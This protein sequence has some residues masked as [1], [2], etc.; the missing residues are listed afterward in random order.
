MS[1]S[2]R[3]TVRQFALIDAPAIPGLVFRGFRDASDSDLIAAIHAGRREHDQVDPLSPVE[4]VPAADEVARWLAGWDARDR[5]DNLLLVD[6]GTQGIGYASIVWW[7]E[8]D[9]TWLYLHE[10]LLRPEWR[11]RGIGTAMVHWAEARIRAIAATHPTGGKAM[12]G[13]NASSTEREASALLLHEGYR[14]VFTVLD[15]AFDA[16]DRLPAPELPARFELRPARPEHDRLIWEAINETYADLTNVPYGGAAPSEEDFQQFAANPAHDRSLWQVAW[17]GDQGAGVVL[18]ELARGRG[19]VTE[20]SVRMPWRRRG[21][22]RALL[23]R[24]LLALRDRGA[25][26]VRLHTTEEFETQAARLYEDV[27]FRVV[28]RHPRYRKPIE[29]S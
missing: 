20:C 18:C 4:R 26:V 15:M 8:P 17:D 19:V 9:G 28:K 16:F 23:V 3:R 11:G 6:V 14:P 1:Q 13:A 5:A 2:T 10:G 24:G 12:Y 21:V 29:A 22:A 25:A 7:T 27:G